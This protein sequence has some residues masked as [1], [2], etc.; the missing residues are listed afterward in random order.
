[1]FP[2]HHSLAYSFLPFNVSTE[3][4]TDIL[5]TKKLSTSGV[6]IVSPV[7]YNDFFV[8][9][10]ED[11]NFY[12]PTNNGFAKYSNS[13][14]LVKNIKIDN[15][16]TEQKVSNLLYTNGKVVFITKKFPVTVYVYNSTTYEKIFSIPVVDEKDKPASLNLFSVTD[17][18]ISPNGLSVYFLTNT[19][20]R[21]YMFS[22]LESSEKRLSYFDLKEKYSIYTGGNFTLAPKIISDSKIAFTSSKGIVYVFDL[23]NLA[24]YINNFYFDQKFQFLNSLSESAV[25]FSFGTA[26]IYTK[27]NDYLCFYEITVGNKLCALYVDYKKKESS[28][29]ASPISIND[30]LVF[31]FNKNFTGIKEYYL[32]SV[33]GDLVRNK[34]VRVLGNINYGGIFKDAKNYVITTSDK[35]NKVDTE[36]GVVLGTSN[37]VYQSGFYVSRVSQPSITKNGDFYVF[38]ESKRNSPLTFEYYIYKY[39]GTLVEKPCPLKIYCNSTPKH[40]PVILIHGLGG[41]Y[42]NFMDEKTGI[43]R[44]KILE[45]YRKDDSEFPDT[46]AY[47]YSYGYTFGGDYNYQGKIEDISSNLHFD[48]ERLSNESLLAGGSGKVDLIGYSLGGLI[49]RHY[50]LEK[51]GYPGTQNL[52]VDTK[53]NKVIFIASPIN[54]SGILE[55]IYNFKANHP[56]LGQTFINTIN[57]TLS[58]WQNE[59]IDITKDIGTQLN[60]EAYYLKSLNTFLLPPNI[61]FYRNYANIKAIYGYKIFDVEITNELDLG[62]TVVQTSDTQL[63]NAPFSSEFLK[64]QNIG[65]FLTYV[66]GH[67]DFNHDLLINSIKFNHLQIPSN[68]E[69]VNSVLGQLKE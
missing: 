60:S 43:L 8:A 23:S 69:V 12:L 50:I 25:P 10:D 56:S 2:Y 35:V 51:T 16:D 26:S 14:E 59:E 30:S 31:L 44:T 38:I 41:H 47:S 53:I 33:G 22:L 61:K 27:F 34:E 39:K 18:A 49:A 58:E 6:N 21:F 17:I 46:W 13:G 4:S 37:I 3:F 19:P 36:N 29:Y 5:F 20:H 1:M 42:Q 63:I 7:L 54:G 15:L 45:E 48:V 40:N 9:S 68:L 62:D 24:T 32:G 11:E 67:L 65:I 52:D 66:G 64:E 57:I 28:E 55:W